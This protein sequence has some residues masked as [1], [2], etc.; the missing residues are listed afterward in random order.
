MIQ[1][2]RV[3]FQLLLPPDRT[4]RLGAVR[5]PE[6]QGWVLLRWWDGRSAT[7]TFLFVIFLL[8]RWGNPTALFPPCPS[9]SGAALPFSPEITCHLFAEATTTSRGVFSTRPHPVSSSRIAH[10][11]T[12]ALSLPGRR[13]GLTVLS[14][15]REPS[16]WVAEMIPSQ[17]SSYLSDKLL[18]G[19]KDRKFQGLAQYMLAP[20]PSLTP[21]LPS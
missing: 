17:V 19:G 20:S 15:P 14:F 2:K 10:G 1:S 8:V 3:C 4:D 7:S 11:R 18:P 9:L 5:T 16:S 12:S 21:G 13:A 6:N